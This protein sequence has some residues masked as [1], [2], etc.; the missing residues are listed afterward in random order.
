MRK[1][2]KKKRVATSGT[3]I[4]FGSHGLKVESAGEIT[5]NQ[6]EAGRRTLARF[7]QKTGKV[8]VRVFPD[9]PLTQKP[10]EVTMG[11]GK[12]DPA[13]YVTDVKAGRIIFEVD[14]LPDEK[15]K[16]ALRAAG[17]KLPLKT[18]IISRL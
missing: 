7:V 9:K 5:S 10:P 17:S 8:W 4:A 13:K 2:P 1:N 11:G 14:G 12:G 3:T 16:E 15:A 6:I 18:R